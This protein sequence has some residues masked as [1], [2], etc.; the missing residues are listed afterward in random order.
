MAAHPAVPGYVHELARPRRRLVDA[1][2]VMV[3]SLAAGLSALDRHAARRNAWE[4]VCANRER[5]RQWEEA[6]TP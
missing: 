5:R 4:A 2:R 3:V 1:T 6:W